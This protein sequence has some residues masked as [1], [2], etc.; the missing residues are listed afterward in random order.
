MKALGQL[1]SAAS[2]CES[3]N[4]V[5]GVCCSSPSCGTCQSCAVTG[6]AGTCR[7]VPAG[8]VEPHGG[9]TGNTPCG[10]IGTCD[11]NGACRQ[12]PTSTSC[13]V[14]SCSGATYTR[15]RALRRQRRLR[16]DGDQ[17]VRPVQVWPRR[18]PDGL[19]GRRRLHGRAVLPFELVHGET[20]RRRM[21]RGRRVHQRHCVEGVCCGSASC[22]SCSSCAVAGQGGDLPAGASQRARPDRGVHDHG[23]YHV[24]DERPVQRQRP[25]RVP[26]GGDA[27]R[28]A[29]VHVGGDLH[30]DVQR[31]RGVRAGADHGDVP[32]TLVA[33]RC[34]APAVRARTTVRPCISA[35]TA[36]ASR[37]A[38]QRCG[39]RAP[40]P[41]RCDAPGAQARPIGD[42][43]N[44]MVVRLKTQIDQPVVGQ[45]GGWF[46]GKPVLGYA[47][48]LSA[49]GLSRPPS[50]RHHLAC[51]PSANTKPR[52]NETRLT[53]KRSSRCVRPIVRPRSTIAWSRSTKPAPRR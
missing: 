40:R 35:I 11:G 17:H 49:V 34:A 32:P 37:T 51:P 18:L 30:P 45:Q 31:Q 16:P 9:C 33:G 50:G 14:A 1:C 43:P 53:P 52:L 29:D 24:R 21:R 15:D 48:Q 25:V 6:L 26:P 5:E 39:T 7:P 2:D 12:A 46:R 8:D 36:C 38:R 41:C 3:N 23:R 44:Q 13:G 4:C 10:F 47:T 20:Q 19:H 22:P 28:R 27:V 42:R